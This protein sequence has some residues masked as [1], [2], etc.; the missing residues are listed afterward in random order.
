MERLKQM[1]LVKNR[2]TSKV[3]LINGLSL[4]MHIAQWIFCQANLITKILEN[5]L[6]LIFSIIFEENI[7]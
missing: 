3:F 4:V 1:I 5:I 7:I 6:Y 2:Q